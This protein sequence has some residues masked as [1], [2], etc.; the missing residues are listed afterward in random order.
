EGNG[1]RDG[2]EHK[3]LEQEA[4]RERVP[5]G[6]R[7]GEGILA[8]GDA[9]PLRRRGAREGKRRVPKSRDER[10]EQDGAADLERASWQALHALRGQRQKAERGDRR[11]QRPAGEEEPFARSAPG[12][13]EPGTGDRRVEQREP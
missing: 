13:R 4:G 5:E 8:A 6:D 7:D 1:Y 12:K 2:G 3:R 11:Q 9:E 10:G